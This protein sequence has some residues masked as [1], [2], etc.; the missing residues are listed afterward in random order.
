MSVNKQLAEIQT[1]LRLNEGLQNAA[2]PVSKTTVGIFL[3][4]CNKLMKNVHNV[5]IIASTLL[6]T[7]MQKLLSR[8]LSLDL[9]LLG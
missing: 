8:C 7:V 9:H 5:G 1:K 2:R 6:Q 4:L 3:G